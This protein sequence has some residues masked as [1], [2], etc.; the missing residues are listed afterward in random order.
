[1]DKLC[2]LHLAGRYPESF[3]LLFYFRHTDTFLCNFCCG[4]SVYLLFLCYIL[5]KISCFTA[6]SLLPVFSKTSP[7][8]FRTFTPKSREKVLISANFHYLFYKFLC[9]FPIRA[10]LTTDL[11]KDMPR[12]YP[13]RTR[14]KAHAVRITTSLSSVGPY[15]SA[16]HRTLTPHHRPVNN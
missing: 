9:T 16:C 4:H 1:M 3:C 12:N 10:Q 2:L 13:L 6:D 8:I 11:N 15:N 14:L 7:Y 5:L